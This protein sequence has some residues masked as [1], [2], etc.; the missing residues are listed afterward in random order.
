MKA[1]ELVK[2]VESEGWVF[3]RQKGSHMVFVK[4][5][6]LRP[7][8]IPNHPSKDIKKKTLLDILK[9]AGLRK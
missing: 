6:T 2:L 9:Q 4:E 7:L 1:R 8:V 3:D 5:G